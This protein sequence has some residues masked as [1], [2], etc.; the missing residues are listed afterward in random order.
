M[1]CGSLSADQHQFNI[2]YFSSISVTIAKDSA[3]VVIT[4]SEKQGKEMMWQD[5]LK[6]L[7]H[8]GVTAGKLNRSDLP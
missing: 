5:M 8:P 3:K 4:Q 2:N 7:H 1:D 6:K